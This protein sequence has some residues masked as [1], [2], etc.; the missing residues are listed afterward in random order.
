MQI[1]TG[2]LTAA[3]TVALAA[4]SGND[5]S[6]ASKREGREIARGSVDVDGGEGSY[7]VRDT[8]D[9]SATVTFTGPD[10]ETGKFKTG[11]GAASYL[12]DFA[13]IY[14]GAVVTAG[15]GGDSSTGT[16]SAVSFTSNDAPDKVVAYY[17]GVAAKAGMKIAAE[18]TMGDTRMLSAADETQGRSLQVQVTAADGGTSGTIIAGTQ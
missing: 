8:G 3:A 5:A 13:P 4:C 11:S 14:P 9:G 18:M 16:G 10:G 17:K 7:S 2:L 1:R 15:A 6:E 12:P